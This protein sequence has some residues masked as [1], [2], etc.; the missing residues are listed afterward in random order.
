MRVAS[1]SPA[2]SLLVLDT[3]RLLNS[4]P[5]SVEQLPFP[6]HCR[7]SLEDALST[8]PWSPH[9]LLKDGGLCR[10]DLFWNHWL[11]Q[12]SPFLDV[13]QVFRVTGQPKDTPC[14][15]VKEHSVLH[16]IHA[17]T[18]RSMWSI[19]LHCVHCEIIWIQNY[20]YILLVSATALQN[21]S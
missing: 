18:K 19:S 17:R 6:G 12:A 5:Y 20:K 16:F 10:L 8:G 14:E 2:S 9:E 1:G 13:P 3:K 4:P 21:L 7:W 11:F 15:A